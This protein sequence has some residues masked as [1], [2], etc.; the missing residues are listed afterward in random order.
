[1]KGWWRKVRHCRLC[2]GNAID[3]VCEEC[4][5]EKTKLKMHFDNIEKLKHELFTLTHPVSYRAN[6]DLPVKLYFDSAV[7]DGD[8]HVIFP[9]S[10]IVTFLL[11]TEN[12]I[13]VDDPAGFCNRVLNVGYKSYK[14]DDVLSLVD[15]FMRTETLEP[16]NICGI[17]KA[18]DEV[19][20]MTEL[21][22][23]LYERVKLYER[24]MSNATL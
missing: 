18:W 10:K 9:M 19:K 22:K 16:Y 23:S 12:D 2:G 4:F 14:D 5:S 1:M 21:S 3:D 15:D 13:W 7:E 20:T 8:D 17:D 6:Q 11:D 24:S